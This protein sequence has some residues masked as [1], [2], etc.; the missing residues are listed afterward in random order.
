MKVSF[1]STFVTTTFLVVGGCDMNSNLPVSDHLD[2]VINLEGEWMFSIG[3]DSAWSSPKYNDR[4]WDEIRVP[5]SW[6][7]EGFH[8]YD[9]YAWYRKHFTISKRYKNYTLYLNLGNIDDADEVY[10][11]GELIGFSGSFPPHYETA[12]N[13]LRIYP[14][15]SSYLNFET[16]NVVSVRVFD[17]ELEGGILRGDIGLFTMSSSLNMDINLE[18]KWDFSIGDDLRWKENISD[19]KNWSSIMVPSFW[20]SQG[21]R[22]YDGYAWYRKKVFIPSSLK[23]K[24]LVLLLGKIDDMDQT[25]LNGKQI[26]N[27]GDFSLLPESFN[28]NEQYRQLR[29]YYIPRDQIRFD[30]E[31]VIVV[32]VYDGFKYGGIYEGPIGI[33]TQDNWRKYWNRQKGDKNIFQKLFGD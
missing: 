23:D 19:N 3:D 1:I 29:E 4:A 7:N 10:I 16:N 13:I 30:Q 14:V 26:G 18:G 12:Y 8:G 22:E 28:L 21:F 20:E 2:K 24:K 25:F 9:G 6:E 17:D 5:S 33:V 32:R 27:T 11:N 31:N 15:P